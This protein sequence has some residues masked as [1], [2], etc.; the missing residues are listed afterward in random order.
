MDMGSCLIHPRLYSY[1]CDDW[2]LML[3]MYYRLLYVSPSGLLLLLVLKKWLTATTKPKGFRRVLRGMWGLAPTSSC[4][5]MTSAGREERLKPRL[6]VCLNRVD[7]CIEC[8]NTGPLNRCGPTFW[9]T[10][11]D[12]LKDNKTN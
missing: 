7:S 5:V 8:L 10:N 9:W 6:V 11:P 2:H 4:S 1:I 3:P 12:F